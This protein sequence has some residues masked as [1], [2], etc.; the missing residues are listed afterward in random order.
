MN[1]QYTTFKTSAMCPNQ[2]KQ[3]LSQKVLVEMH[4]G[5]DP[6][7]DFTVTQLIS[8]V[9]ALSRQMEEAWRIKIFKGGTMLNTKYEYNHGIIPSLTTQSRRTDED[10]LPIIEMNSLHRAE[11]HAYA[12][13]KRN[14]EMENIEEPESRPKKKLRMIQEEVQ[15]TPCN[16]RKL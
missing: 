4:G 6:M 13:A 9:S 3:Q 8:H 11:A 15:H 7:S 12:E 10:Q 2:K 5:G 16:K 1:T 14:I